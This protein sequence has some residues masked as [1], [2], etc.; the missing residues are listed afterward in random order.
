MKK[1][2]SEIIFQYILYILLIFYGIITLYPVYHVIMYSISNPKSAMGG[3]LFLIPKGFSLVSFKLLFG[4]KTVFIAYR[5]TIFVTLVGTLINIILTALLAYPLSIKRFMGRNV[6]SLL[7]YFTMLFRG[8]MIPL[9]LLVRNLGL[10]DSIWSLIIPGSISAWNMFIMKNYFQGLPNELEESAS[11][12]G[13][14]PATILIR[15]ILPISKPMIAAIALFYAVAHWNS[16]FN[17]ILYI[18]TQ[19]KQTL[20][21]F[22]RSMLTYTSMQ[23]MSTAQDLEALGELTEESVKMATIVLSVVPMLMVYPFLQKYFVKGILIGSVKG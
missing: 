23:Q 14:G 9:Y 13:A 6:I 15:I 22:L 19:S 18:S 12:D 1:A 20:Q 17:C 5:N 2:K 21:V 3:G 16:Y 10:L 7:I 4:T 8:G 11:L